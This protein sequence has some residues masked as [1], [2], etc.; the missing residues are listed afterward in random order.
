MLT[1]IGIFGSV[2]TVVSFVVTYPLLLNHHHLYTHHHKIPSTNMSN[3]Y[4]T[5]PKLLPM[6]DISIIFF[7]SN[8]WCTQWTKCTVLWGQAKE[9]SQWVDQPQGQPS[10][11]VLSTLHQTA[12]VS[13][14]YCHP[15]HWLLYKQEEEIQII[16]HLFP[17]SNGIPGQHHWGND[18]PY[19]LHL[20]QRSQGW[21]SNTFHH[22]LAV[23][24]PIGCHDPSFLFQFH[25]NVPTN[26]EQ[27][28][29]MKFS[30]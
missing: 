2:L 12:L 10:W 27:I 21:I 15:P 30:K 19:T 20:W 29:Y 28:T 5:N 26:I 24:F 25:L 18:L 9:P 1:C 23:K 3:R 13:C 14:P 7:K 8:T 22:Y 4:Y 16:L 6:Y 17:L 11:T